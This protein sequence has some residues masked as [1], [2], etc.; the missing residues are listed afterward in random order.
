MDLQKI[1]CLCEEMNCYVKTEWQERCDV[2]LNEIRKEILETPRESLH[3]LIDTAKNSEYGA[4]WYSERGPIQITKEGELVPLMGTVLVKLFG[5]QR[6]T[7]RLQD[8][9]D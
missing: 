5:A 2:L 1:L 7:S 6:K 9:A 8:D 3:E 4:V